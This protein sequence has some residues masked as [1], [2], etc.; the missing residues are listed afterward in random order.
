M[1]IAN[2]AE[3]VEKLEYVEA[4]VREKLAGV[5][6]TVF[7]CLLKSHFPSEVPDDVFVSTTDSGGVLNLT[8]WLFTPRLVVQIRNPLDRDRIQYEMA[9]FENAVDWIRLNARKFDLENSSDDSQLELEFSTADGLTQEL[10]ATGKG[11]DHLMRVY[12]DRFLS[13][14]KTLERIEP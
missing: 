13:N 4:S 10:S 5:V 6:G 2:V 9:P 11:C 14:F 12:R 8:A 3:Y 7:D 1:S